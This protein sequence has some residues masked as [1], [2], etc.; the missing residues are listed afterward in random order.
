[1][2]DRRPPGSLQPTAAEST[3]E[4]TV[5]DARG[6]RS[7]ATAAGLASA[8]V[9]G[10]PT[11]G[12]ALAKPDDVGTI[13]RSTGWRGG[14]ALA[15]P[16]ARP[17][18][19]SRPAP[20]RLTGEPATPRRAAAGRPARRSF[21]RLCAANLCPQLDTKQLPSRVA[22]RSQAQKPHPTATGT[23]RRLNQRS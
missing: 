4:Q 17:W 10:R 23:E 1:M 22:D 12:I 9:L 5:L 14:A 6:S 7:E 13:R 11:A 3:S 19:P 8:A 20:N 18:P 21:A 2:T 16:T 15:G